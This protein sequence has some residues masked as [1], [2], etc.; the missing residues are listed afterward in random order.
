MTAQE[1]LQW[2]KERA[3]EELDLGRAPGFVD[4]AGPL[5]I[6]TM[7]RILGQHPELAE[8]QRDAVMTSPFGHGEDEIRAWVRGLVYA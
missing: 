6:T 7:I 4:S 5:A 1:T 3:L 2:A 8:L